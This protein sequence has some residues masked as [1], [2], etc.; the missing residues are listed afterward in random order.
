MWGVKYAPGEPIA[1]DTT[2]AQ[3][4]TGGARERFRRPPA[5]HT[6]RDGPVHRKGEGAVRGRVP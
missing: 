2:P 1:E 5:L 4:R 3:Q 6:E